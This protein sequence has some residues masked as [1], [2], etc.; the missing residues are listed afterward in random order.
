MRWDLAT[1]T[2]RNEAIR[3]RGPARRC[4]RRRERDGP[5]RAGGAAKPERGLR[6]RRRGR[7]VRAMSRGRGARVARLAPPRRVRRSDVPARLRRRAAGVLRRLSRPGPRRAR[8]RDRVRRLPRRARPRRPCEGLRDLPRVRVPERRA[9][10]QA[11]ADAVDSERARALRGVA[12]R[13]LGRVL[14]GVPHA[15]RRERASQPRLHR[16]PR[17]GARALV[18]RGDRDAPIVIGG[19]HRPHPRGGR[20]L[21]PPPAISS[22]GSR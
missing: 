5:H 17:R 2:R 1:G 21:R 7:R 9:R 13:R 20:P 16:R 6:G 10:R 8:A 11:R 14:R 12:P 3:A 4:A 18:D 19:A 15:A 22:G